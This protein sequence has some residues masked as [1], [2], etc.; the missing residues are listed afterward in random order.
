[1]AGN[2]RP[3]P[4]YDSREDVAFCAQRNHF[5]LV[6]GLTTDGVVSALE[7]HYIDAM[8]PETRISAIAH[9]IQLA[10]APVFLISGVATLLSVL[11]NRLGRI[12]D[13]ARVLEAKIE[14][15]DEAKR[16]H[17]LEELLRLSRRARLVNLAITLGT[18]CALLTCVTI[19]TLFTGTFLAINLSDVITVL[20]IAA[21]LSLFLALMAFLREVLIAT[22]G[23]RISSPRP[24]GEG[25]AKALPPLVQE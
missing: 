1:M 15:P 18:I 10:I 6:A 25:T 16:A 17:M 24:G 4:I 11:A 21:M 20:F 19:A 2:Y 7:C 8:P 13:R 23:L 12:V 22:R 3:M 14:L 9:V 5:D